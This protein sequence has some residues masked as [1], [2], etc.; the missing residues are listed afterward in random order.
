MSLRALDLEDFG[1][2]AGPDAQPE[3]ASDRRESDRLRAY[4]EG[5]ATGW[6]EA[7]ADARAAAEAAQDQ[8]DA[9]R[10]RVEELGFTF[11]E[12]R[13]HVMQ[14]VAPMLRAILE[15]GLPQLLHATLGARLEHEFA[16]MI[17]SYGDQPMTLH[18]AAADR[19]QIAADLDGAFALP[20][21]I[22]TDASLDSG[23]MVLAAGPL[24][25][26]IDIAAFS[27]RLTEILG[28][29]EHSNKELLAN[30]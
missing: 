24:E 20:L 15:H 2:F 16:L 25:H 6:A 7:Q 3:T 19:A 1:S 11:Q 27:A 28:S 5:Y 9:L 18:V 12:A 30:G 21:D 17:E 13:A 14:A 4:D 26:E 10:A 23:Q 29:I 8:G 22:A